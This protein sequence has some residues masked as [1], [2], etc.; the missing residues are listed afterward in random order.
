M[1]EGGVQFDD[2]LDAG[3]ADRLLQPFTGQASGGGRTRYGRRRTAAR[4]EAATPLAA[5]GHLNTG[6]TVGRS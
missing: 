1:T 5:I 2:T 3:L 6:R 4:A